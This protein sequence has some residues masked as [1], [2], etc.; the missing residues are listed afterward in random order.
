[1]GPPLKPAVLLLFAYGAGLATGL[2]RFGDPLVVAVVLSLAACWWWRSTMLVWCLAALLGRGSAHAALSLD[3]SSCRVRL[4]EGTLGAELRVTEPVSSDARLARVEIESAGCLGT[5]DARWPDR[6]QVEA[7]SRGRVEGRWIRRPERGGR[8]DG[9]LIIREFTLARVSP[10]PV[11]RLRNWLA[12]TVR[13]LYGERTGTVEAL[14]VNRRGGMAPELRDRYGRAGLVH[15][16]SISGFHVGV[17]LA[18]VVMLARMLNLP[19]TRGAL[20]ASGL[21]FLYVL[22]L[23]W[24]PPAARAALLAGLAAQ[25]HFRQRNPQAVSLLAVT[26]L[27]VVILDPWAVLDAGAWLSAS[28]LLGA[29]LAGRWSDRALGTAW[30]WRMLSASIGAT[31]A[32][33]PITAALFGMVSVAGILLNFAAIPLA[34]LAVPG[35]LL[36]LLAAALVPPLAA[37]LAAGSGALLGLLDQLAWWG[38]QSDA[39]AIIQPAAPASALPWLGVLAVAAWGISGRAPGWEAARRLALG[40]CAGTWLLLL[41][42][43]VRTVH[44]AD[45]GLSLH[46]LDIGQGDAALLRTPAG[47][48]VLIDAGPRSDRDDAGRR[49]VAPFLAQHRA[50]G[51]ALAIISHAHADHLGG[52]PAVLDRYPAAAVLEPA[53]LVSDSLYT[54]FLDQLEALGVPWRPARDGLKLEL[55]SVRFTVLHPDTAWTEWRVDLNED[56]VVLLVEYGGFRALFPGDGG[57]H[58]ESRLAGRIG[59]VDLLK[60]GH[61][62]S[63]SASGEAWLT[64][65]APHAAII[66]LGRGNRYGHPH[67][68]VIDRLT[69]HGIGIWRTD[70]LGTITVTTDGRAVT[71]DGRGRHQTFETRGHLG[72]SQ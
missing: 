23:A 72:T 21:A 20:L 49:V 19:R 10:S 65:L 17:I 44:D 60:V 1:M 40:A 43:G 24:P 47:H 37:P 54:G 9:I 30:W 68:E 45:S 8:A 33:A 7:G 32:T 11:E 48:W 71:I 18:W 46:F 58:A 55:D 26:C 51:L 2:L 64:E 27:L 38:G 57:L 69:R 22:F 59:A 70:Q 35:L 50:A 61:H 62:G 15:I 4:A 14:I 39:A 36:S 66:S 28:A 53:E 52:L 56:S 42:D 29:L 13:R 5:V 67:A 25:S 34:A 41:A 6:Q 31:L 63:R 16:L 12:T 3:A